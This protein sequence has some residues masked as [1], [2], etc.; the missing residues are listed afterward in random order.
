M[1]RPVQRAAFTMIELLVLLGM[2]TMAAAAGAVA[3]E[4]SREAA[5]RATCMHNLKVLG[6]AAHH[7]HDMHKSLPPGW[8]GGVG[9]NVGPGASPLPTGPGNGPFPQLLPFLSSQKLFDQLGKSILWDPQIAS[10]DFWNTQDQETKCNVAAFRVACT[11]LKVLQCPSDKDTPL[12][13]YPEEEG[14]GNVKDVQSYVLT[15][16]T[17]SYSN[18]GTEGDPATAKAA[19]PLA[20]QWGHSGPGEWAGFLFPTTYDSTTAAYNPMA[21]VNYVPVAGLGH[22]ESPF[23]NQFEGVF[24]NRSATTLRAISAADGTANTLMFGESSGQFYPAFG[25]N[26][27]QNNLFAAVGTP[28]HRG[29]QQRCAPGV[30]AGMPAG[31]ASDCDNVSY[32]TGDSQKARFGTFSSCHPGGVLFCFCDGSVRM[33]ARGQTWKQGSPDWYLFQQLAGFHDGFRR[34]TRRLF[35]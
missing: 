15:Q 1:Q 5:N 30:N 33:M 35:P 8:W 17:Y 31:A 27:L 19:N 22:G 13:K 28:T 6:M 4:K 25:D 2:I 11:P 26:T 18:G 23:Y 21:R 20:V 32:K 12:A 3:I 7:Y 9:R 34:D 16:A 10:V 29:L 24:T 14:Q